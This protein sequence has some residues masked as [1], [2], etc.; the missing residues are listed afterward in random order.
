ME[1]NL[2]NPPTR[3]AAARRTR[4]NRAKVPRGS[5]ASREQQQSIR[6]VTN[7]WT[8]VSLDWCVRDVCMYV[9]VC[10]CVC[11]YVCMYV[12]PPVRL[13]IYLFVCLSAYVCMAIY[14]CTSIYLTIYGIYIAPFKVT[15][16]GRSQPR[17]GRKERDLE[18]FVD[19]TGQNPWYRRVQF[20]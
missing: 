11:M 10:V 18:K 1:E 17:P 2:D 14:V 4:S 20:R 19:G 12:C 3:R 15:T 13:S 6:L 5:P 9:C 7:A 8:R 16:Q